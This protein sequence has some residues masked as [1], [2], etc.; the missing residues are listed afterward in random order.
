MAN[1]FFPNGEI[2]IPE[3]IIEPDIATAMGSRVLEISK[4]YDAIVCNRENKGKSLNID[5]GVVTV[6]CLFG[7]G[8]RNRISL[9]QAD[10]DTVSECRKQFLG[11]LPDKIMFDWDYDFFISA[12]GGGRWHV[13]SRRDVRAIVN[14]SAFPTQL[15]VATTW[16]R[17]ELG[18]TNS[19]YD[20]YVTGSSAKIEPSQWRT[21]VSKPGEAV[22]INNMAR[23][24]RQ[25]PHRAVPAKDRVILR[26]FAEPTQD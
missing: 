9:S 14:L 25:I 11:R 23:S 15:E 19:K 6:T 22:G 2:F 10:M 17:S 13:D 26:I 3:S 18:G 24:D 16:D 8:Y 1:L 5:E 20:Y 21:L 12:V 4:Q 7:Q